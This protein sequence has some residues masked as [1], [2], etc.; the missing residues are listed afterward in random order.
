[1]AAIQEPI[2]GLVADSQHA[3]CL[4]NRHE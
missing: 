1:V 2:H 4:L 3:G